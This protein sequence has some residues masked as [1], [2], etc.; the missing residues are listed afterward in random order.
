MSDVATGRADVLVT[1]G[2]IRY[3]TE[4]KREM[5]RVDKAKLE[6][7]YVQQAAEYGNTNVPLGQL[8]VLD[9]APHADGTSRIDESM[10]VARHRPQGTSRDRSVVVGV[11]AG[12]RPTPSGLST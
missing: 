6:A 5:A 3:L 11:V 4:I 9:L 1:F 2:T 12:N 8:L 7:K 10:W